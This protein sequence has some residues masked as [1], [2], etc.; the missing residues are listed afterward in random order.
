M[1]FLC[2]TELVIKY[3]KTTKTNRENVPRKK[4]F[5]L[6]VEQILAF[7]S[8]NYLVREVKDLSPN[9][10]IMFYAIDNSY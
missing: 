5:S 9:S 6:I 3:V 10:I 4:T 1:V 2:N 7:A 8:I